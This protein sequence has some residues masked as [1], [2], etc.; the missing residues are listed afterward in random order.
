[1][2]A[3]VGE[4]IVERSEMVAAQPTSAAGPAARLLELNTHLETSA[5]RSSWKVPEHPTPSRR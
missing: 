2:D 5:T 1:V 4:R 3:W